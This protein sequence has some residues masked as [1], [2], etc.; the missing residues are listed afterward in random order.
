MNETDKTY[1]LQDQ[2]ERKI[3]RFVV[4]VVQLARHKQAILHV[5]ETRAAIGTSPEGPTCSRLGRFPTTGG[6]KEAS[7]CRPWKV[8]PTRA[9]RR[10]LFEIR[11]WVEATMR[12]TVTKILGV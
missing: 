1:D 10:T 7:S 5:R 3:P 9:V 6:T 4:V 2:G 11:A 12:V 8:C